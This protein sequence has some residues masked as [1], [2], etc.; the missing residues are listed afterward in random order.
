MKAILLLK[1]VIT[2]TIDKYLSKIILK[3]TF[4]SK[5]SINTEICK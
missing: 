3:N 5:F 4:K 1:K 2:V